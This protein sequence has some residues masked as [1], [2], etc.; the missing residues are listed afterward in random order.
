MYSGGGEERE[1]ER[2][3]ERVRESEREG[4]CVKERD[5]RGEGSIHG[6]AYSSAVFPVSLEIR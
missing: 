6:M 3:R 1:R 2:D 4:A 5:M